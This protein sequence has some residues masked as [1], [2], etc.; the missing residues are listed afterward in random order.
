MRVRGRTHDA[1]SIEAY[2]VEMLIVGVFDGRQIEPAASELIKELGQSAR[3]RKV[4][5][6][7]S[8][9]PP[10]PQKVVRSRSSRVDRATRAKKSRSQRVARA[11]QGNLDETL[12]MRSE[13]DVQEA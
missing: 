8:I 4:A 6:G 9:K 11:S 10:G 2:S 3:A 12:P 7:G 1:G 13:I 5:R